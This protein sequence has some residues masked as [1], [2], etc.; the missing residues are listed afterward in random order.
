M[1][2][3]PLDIPIEVFVADLGTRARKILND[4]MAYFLSFGDEYM[5][6]PHT[7]RHLLMLSRK[8]IKRFPNLGKKSLDEIE[9]KL[10]NLG[11]QLWDE[12][13]ERSLKLLREHPLYF[14]QRVH[15]TDGSQCW[16]NPEMTYK[17]PDNGAEVWVHKEP[18]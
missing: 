18:A 15:V 4:E 3:H 10:R 13:D 1:K 5:R 2:V 8:E 12:H 6:P 16:C 17:D 9:D 11:L 14:N 7:V